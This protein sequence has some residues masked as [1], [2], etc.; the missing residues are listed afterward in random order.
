MAFA[1][2]YGRPT[3]VSNSTERGATP[4]DTVLFCWT[5]IDSSHMSV[6]YKVR[7]SI[8]LNPRVRI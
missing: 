6:N 8:A 4:F 1:F 2:K 7:H 3:H 5:E